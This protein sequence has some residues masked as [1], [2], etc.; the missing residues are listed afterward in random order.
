MKKIISTILLVV[1]AISGFT[2]TNTFPSSGNA[3]IGT[4]SP[5]AKLEI[6]GAVRLNPG[7]TGYYAEHDYLGTTY[8]FG[9]SE[10]S[11]NVRFNIAG[12]GTWTTGGGFNF[13][14]AGSTKLR[15]HKDGNI[16]IGTTSPGAP[17]HI[18]RDAYGE[19][20]RISAYN[21][22]ASNNGISIGIRGVIPAAY[23]LQ[24]SYYSSINNGYAGDDNSLLVINDKGYND[25]A[26]FADFA[27]GNG[28][29]S[30]VLFVDGSASN[31]GI[32]TTSPQNLLHVI[33]S[34]VVPAI[35]AESSSTFGALQ[36]KS[37]GGATQD[38]MIGADISGISGGGLAFYNNAASSYRMV[39]TGSGNLGIGVISPSEKLSVNGNIAAKKL[40]VTQT[41][42]SDYVFNKDYKLRNL[43]DLETFINKNK[44]LPEVPTAKE[45][46]T[47]GISVGDNQ[48]LLLKKIEELT[49][50]MIEMNKTNDQ[51]KAEIKVQAKEIKLLKQMNKR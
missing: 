9:I 3:G 24:T 28:K 45:V 35:K 1:S 51:M 4:T 2:Q 39:L 18:R 21:D 10:V 16:G 49:L 12:G 32:G 17:L 31:V 6:V 29:G 43:R 42:W 5:G 30:P 36:L 13:Q 40:I 47:K 22:G 33:S 27:V 15:I 34:S 11:D 7:A 26:K 14:L 25:G 23:G 38:W 46:A 20:F 44:H 50:Y 19:Q 8:N 37:T 41:G 48:V